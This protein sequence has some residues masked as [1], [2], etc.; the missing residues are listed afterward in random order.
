MNTTTYLPNIS[1]PTADEGLPSI[2]SKKIDGQKIDGIL[3][4]CL[5]IP[6]QDLLIAFI[7]K[8]AAM[9]GVLEDTIRSLGRLGCSGKAHDEELSWKAECF[10]SPIVGTNVLE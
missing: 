3:K 7:S 1:G 4:L 2:Q 9:R 5:P 10:T 6:P 8:L